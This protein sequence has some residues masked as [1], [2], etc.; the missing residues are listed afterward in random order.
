MKNFLAIV[1]VIV[2]A[3]FFYLLLQTRGDLISE[4]NRTT[5]FT[6]GKYSWARKIFQLHNPG[7][8]R[9]YYLTGKGPLIVEIVTADGTAFSETLLNEFKAEI[10]RL[11]GREVEIF[12][13]DRIGGGSLSNAEIS[14]IIKTKRRRLLPAQS[15]LF[16]IYASDYNFRG[17]EAS[18]TLWEYGILVSDQRVTELA[19]RYGTPKDK[20]LKSSLLHFFGKQ[21]GL[22]NNDNQS[23]VMYRKV[24][25]VDLQGKVDPGFT[26]SEYCDF[27][28]EELEAIKKRF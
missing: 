11:I 27:E 7:D 3:I 20:F 5:R 12:N 17:E 23:C 21:M 8:A 9:K 28:I 25:E 13:E 2:G 18:R 6:L 26:V 19:N 1:F 4:F 15:N 22:S 14:E 16:I 10:K 24:A